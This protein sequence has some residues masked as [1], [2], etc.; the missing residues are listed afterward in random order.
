MA[1]SAPDTASRE[2]APRL[3][4]PIITLLVVLAISLLFDSDIR[5][6]YRFGDSGYAVGRILGHIIGYYILHGVVFAVGRLIRRKTSGSRSFFGSRLNYVS[7]ALYL[8]LSLIMRVG[9]LQK[10]GLI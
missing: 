10:T 9:Q 2:S 7:L 8:L 3:L 5:S 4:T 6:A 1:N